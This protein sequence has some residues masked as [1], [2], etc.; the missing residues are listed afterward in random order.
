MSTLRASGTATTNLRLLCFE[1]HRGTCRGFYI[2]NAIPRF[3]ATRYYARMHRHTASIKH[4]E[5]DDYLGAFIR[6]YGPLQFRREHTK[7]PF[8]ALCESIIYQ[9]LSGKAAATILK[10]FVALWPKKSFPSPDDVLRIKIEKLRSAGLSGQKTSYIK[11]LALRFKDG[12]INPKLFHK[13]SD[14]QI[15]EHIVVVKG[16][17]EWTAQMFLMFTLGRPDILPTGDLGIQKAMQK[18]FRLRN[19]PSPERMI[20]LAKTWEGHR[21]VA[22]FYLWRTL[23]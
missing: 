15:V 17:G 19:K 11:D 18:V 2:G 3:C 20:K 21:T 4:L 6:A 8:Q 12:T 23:D 5:N 13:M 10:R 7:E 16:I 14:Q 9:Q 22:C 1:V